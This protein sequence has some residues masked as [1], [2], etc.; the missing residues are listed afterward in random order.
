M[1]QKSTDEKNHQVPIMSKIYGLASSVCVWIG[2]ADKDSKIALDFIKDEVLRIERF[3]ELCEDI[4]YS[5][6][7]GA[8]VN[9]MK[10]PWFSRRWVVQ[11]IALA[12]E[13][14][15]YCGKDSIS[16]KNFSDAVQLF[17]EVETT[18]HKLSEVMK[19]APKF[20]HV[21][22]WFQYV[23]CFGC[24]SV[25]SASLCLVWSTSC[26]RCLC[27]RQRNREIQ[28]A[29]AHL[30]AWYRNLKAKPYKV[31][32]S[33]PFIAICQEF[34]LFSIRQS[35]NRTQALDIICRP[36][37][38]TPTPKKPEIKGEGHSKPDDFPSKV[39]DDQTMPSW[40]PKLSGA[41]YAM[42]THPNGELKMGRQNADP[43][44]GLPGLSHRNYSAAG[45][46]GA[47]F[48]V[49]R[50]RK[51]EG[52][53]SMYVLGF[54]LDQV[55]KVSI[56]SQS[57]NIHEE[58]VSQGGRKDINDDPPQEF[59]RTLVADRGKLGRDAPKYYAR[60]CKESITKG[61]PSG[62]LNTTELINDVRSSVVAEFFRRVQAVI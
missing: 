31:D 34:I 28:S 41:A 21:P 14:V 29:K 8:M 17:V 11:E 4:A 9:L 30:N 5:H 55:G 54:V 52:H 53:F 50:F 24:R 40:I 20:Y 19:M 18:T 26:L 2:A 42:Y 39:D 6:K 15:I 13:A 36:W 59:W 32:Y 62:S 7:W 12:N 61:L 27:S 43:L 23:Y 16:W 60:A 25:R 48:D 45:N 46:R 47:N 1:N 22:G 49:L 37:A 57:G 58:W 38:P 10:R 33:L 44:V 3:D 35:E 56:R 51:R